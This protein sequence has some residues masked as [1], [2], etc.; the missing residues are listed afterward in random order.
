M[1]AYRLLLERI[2]GAAKLTFEEIERKV[3][4]KRAKLSGLV[5]REGAAHIVAA[6]LGVNFDREKFTIAELGTVKRANFVAQLIEVGPIRSFSKQGREGKVANVLLGDATGTI[7]AVF[8][9]T[10]H[11]GLFENKQLIAGD[12]VE[13]MN[14]TMRNGEVHLSSFADIKKSAEH[15]A[16]IVVQ[17]ASVTEGTFAAIT[18]GMKGLFRAFI[19]QVFEPRYFEVC[20]ECGK[21]MGE[22]GC[23]VH[24]ASGSEKRALVTLVLDDGTETIRAVLFMQQLLQLGFTQEELFSGELFGAKRTALLG[25]EY[26]ITGQVRQNTL[27]NATE[28]IVER[29]DP[30][31]PSVLLAALQARA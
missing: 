7:R 8:W 4:G 31:V 20:K 2:A 14:A 29:M 5:S 24:G 10:N 22:G 11:I 28:L 12:T 9:D 13:I 23:A 25:E 16:G 21:R 27:Y 19:V 3:E 30:L 18:P 26:L 6:E 1:D 17:T 15:I